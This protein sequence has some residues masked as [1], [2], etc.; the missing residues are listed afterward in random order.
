MS[1]L[2]LQ[3][4][5]WHFNA[6]AD[7]EAGGVW[8]RN[9]RTVKDT[10]KVVL[11]EQAPRRELLQTL[12]CEVEKILNATPLFDVPVESSDDEVLTPFHFLLG[13]ATPLYPPGV[14]VDETYSL[15]KR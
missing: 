3:G 15:R 14:F 6:P 11:E 9:I 4:V 2:A 13:R 10:L 12:L 1:K 5:D 7:P 8:E